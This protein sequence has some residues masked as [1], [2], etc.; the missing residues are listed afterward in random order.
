MIEKIPEDSEVRQDTSQDYIVD[1][2]PA[3][4]ETESIKEIGR[5]HV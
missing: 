1:P 2:N 3:P 5:A 4:L